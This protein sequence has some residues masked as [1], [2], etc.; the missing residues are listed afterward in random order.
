MIDAIENGLG[1]ARIARSD[2]PRD[3]RERRSQEML[4]RALNLG[5]IVAFVGSG[6]SRAFGLPSWNAFVDK[7]YSTLNLD[8][9]EP[10]RVR[11]A[12]PDEAVANS[13]LLGRV[14]QAIQSSGSRT[15]L[16]QSLE[17]MA[18]DFGKLKNLSSEESQNPLVG[19]LALS[20]TRFVTTNYDVALEYWLAKNQHTSY[21][22]GVDPESR[23]LVWNRA[24]TLIDWPLVALDDKGHRSFL[25]RS[26]LSP[27]HGSSSSTKKEET[28]FYHAERSFS[29]MPENAG[30]LAEFILAR[31]RRRQPAMVF[32]CHGR[33][34]HPESMVLTEDD[35]QKW[36]LDDRDDSKRDFRGTIDLLLGSNPILFL[37]YGLSDY[38][39]LRTLRIASASDV[40]HKDARPLFALFWR[41][42]TTNC[43]DFA[44]YFFEAYGVHVI[45]YGEG[46][47]EEDQQ[48]YFCE[49]LIDLRIQWEAW[50]EQWALKPVFRSIS[51][52]GK[53]MKKNA[54]PVRLHHKPIAKDR[55]VLAK[56]TVERQLE[57]LCGCVLRPKRT[58][59]KKGGCWDNHVVVF[60]GP[61][62][63][64]K[65]HHA[66][67]L[68]D[69][70]GDDPEESPV[71]G[72]GKKK[73]RLDYTCG[74][75]WSSYY[76]ND[77]L[78]GIDRAIE[79]LKN[80]METNDQRFETNP[81]YEKQQDR[82]D[83]F[84]W[85]VHNVTALLV[86]DGFERLLQP[87]TAQPVS[88][89]P[90]PLQLPGGGVTDANT[91]KAPHH[92]QGATPG[93]DGEKPNRRNQGISDP[94]V[95]RA[96]SANVDRFL[97]I[98]RVH[99]S[100][101]GKKKV[102]AGA[103]V[104][105]TS[106]L[107]PENFGDLRS[108]ER[109]ITAENPMEGSNKRREETSN[110]GRG[111][112]A[113]HVSALTAN[114]I[115]NDQPFNELGATRT[116]ELCSLL[117]GHAYGL[118]IAQKHFESQTNSDPIALIRRLQRVPRDAR[119]SCMI[120]IT[121]EAY[122]KG[123]PAGVDRV[124]ARGFLERLATF[125]GPVD[126]ATLAVCL[127]TA[128]YSSGATGKVAAPLKEVARELVEDLWRRRLVFGVEDSESQIERKKVPELWVLHPV[129]R[130]YVF[131]RLHGVKSEDMPNFALPGFT[132]G[133]AAVDPGSQI[134]GELVTDLLDALLQRAGEKPSG[135]T[136]SAEAGK[137]DELR[138]LCR[139]AF[140]VMRS[141][142]EATSAARWCPYDKYI[143]YGVRLINLARKLSPK[144]RAGLW[145][146]AEIWK[147][148]D[149]TFNVEDSEGILY[150]EELA[151]LYNDLGLALCCEGDMHDTYAVWEQGFEINQLIE[152]GQDSGQFTVQSKLHLSHTYMELGNIDAADRW[153]EETERANTI[154]DSRDY[155][156]R[157]WGY[158]AL[159]AHLRGS[160]QDAESMY[161]N[162]RELFRQEG[163]N[164]RAE[165]I[166]LQHWAD[167]KISTRDYSQAKEFL[168][169]SRSLAEHKQHPDLVAYVRNSQGHL[170]RAQRQFDKARHEYDA[171]LSE[172]RRMGIRRLEADVLSELSRLALDQGEHDAA[173]LRA[174]E[175][176]RL[177][178]ELGLGLR[179]C[180]GL[181]VLGLANVAANRHDLGIAYLQV[182]HRL[183]RESGYWLRAQEAEERLRRLGVAP[184][185]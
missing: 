97:E 49:A 108:A 16:R 159:L 42:D 128:G 71:R 134:A 167:L 39:L 119:V 176:M 73:P 83:K 99:S 74:Y 33:C 109:R 59:V 154:L 166:F 137:P 36:Y 48:R 107:W 111:V 86:F 35:Y 18:R 183:S 151:W 135:E 163:G 100:E 45:W 6:C 90:A 3:Q 51:T 4:Y 2:W 47:K 37:G 87:L 170:Y 144:G 165:S 23:Q 17:T 15:S 27:N 160:V 140:G 84:E 19:L 148:T 177:A 53:G 64:G 157:I 113:Y 66:L 182:A 112:A 52:V 132:T 34:D 164:P 185:V 50:Q 102:K 175:A 63:G 127:C 117:R 70:L 22:T 123:N 110:R 179:Q 158:K 130:G 143:R 61:G 162:A 120:A 12:L 14:K 9:G 8:G 178:N 29:Q 44:D 25:Q 184:E 5:T 82:F 91:Q 121:V 124:I 98:L 31:T 10:M 138:N 136:N 24:G 21:A 152:T 114:D 93:A 79:F 80:Q 76:A 139:A 96:N 20:V 103:T 106:R 168:R 60:L 181:V 171:A 46:L 105:L 149:K 89:R 78:T 28:V 38:E 95:G 75:F 43:H 13:F 41:G 85:L 94:N 67:M 118:R 88:H 161:S 58:K 104:I 172:A 129:V 146:R 122:E 40:R 153:L 69:W 147:S 180:H 173:R 101:N 174:M 126:D 141:R 1:A 55:D 81:A 30:Q 125:M 115:A 32:H 11:A 56:A 155:D 7:A 145:S 150:P 72:N 131:H 133:T 156:G 142:M 169:D 92:R 57:S 26:S 68:L 65:S 54:I 116:T 77:W 62:G